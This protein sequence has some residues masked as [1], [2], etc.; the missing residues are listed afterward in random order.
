LLRFFSRKRRC[1]RCGSAKIEEIIVSGDWT[2]EGVKNGLRNFDLYPIR[3]AESFECA[4][5]K[6]RWPNP[7][8]E[9][10]LL[11]RAVK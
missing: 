7:E 6:H 8:F 1:P 3:P 11:S 2:E 9:R 10:F 4:D 5:C